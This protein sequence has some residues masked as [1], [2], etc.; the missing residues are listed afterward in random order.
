MLSAEQL[1]HADKKRN[2][3]HKHINLDDRFVDR[4]VQRADADTSYKHCL[5]EL[6]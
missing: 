2:L 1:R 4:R 6:R 3:Q 5:Y